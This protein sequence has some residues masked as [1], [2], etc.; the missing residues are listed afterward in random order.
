MIVKKIITAV[1]TLT[2][3]LMLLGIWVYA[4]SDQEPIQY[5]GCTAIAVSPGAS[6]DGSSMTTHT[7]DSGTDTFHVNMVPA[8]DYEPGTMRSVLK[9]TD[10]GPYAHLKNSHCFSRRNPSGR[11]Y[12]CLY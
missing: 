4:S 12:L 11:T 3:V 5:S 7:D 6:A 1:I 8:A 9:H 10:Y 2:L